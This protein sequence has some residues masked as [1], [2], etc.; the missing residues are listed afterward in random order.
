MTGLYRCRAIELP[1]VCA[2]WTVKST[3]AGPALGTSKVLLEM[4]AQLGAAAAA[5]AARPVSTLPGFEE[6][7]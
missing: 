6:Q 5:A 3:V 1:V 2:P 7:Q 4:S